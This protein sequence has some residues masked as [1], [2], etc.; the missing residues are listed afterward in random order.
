M[1]VP[2]RQFPFVKTSGN[3]LRSLGEGGGFGGHP[4]L[5]KRVPSRHIVAS[6]NGLP[7]EALENSRAIKENRRTSSLL[8]P[9][10]KA[11][12]DTLRSGNVFRPDILWR[13]KMACHP[14]LWRIPE[15]RV[16]EP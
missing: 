9:F 15:R 16:V 7:P 5:C 1:I 4:S 8:S 13:V 6:E 11:S 14:K 3:I 12:G 2:L 10:A